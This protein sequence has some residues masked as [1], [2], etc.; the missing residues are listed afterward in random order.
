VYEIVMRATIL[1]RM[2]LGKTLVSYMFRHPW[3][4]WGTNV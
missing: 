3:R 4:A 2:Y 1:L